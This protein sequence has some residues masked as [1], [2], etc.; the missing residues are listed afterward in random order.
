[1]RNFLIILILSTTSF[2]A[3]TDRIFST[4]NRF[5]SSSVKA[6]A[7]AGIA[8]PTGIF[9]GL[10]NPALTFSNHQCMNQYNGNVSAGYG[11][12]SIFNRYILPAGLTYSTDEGSMGLFCR[13][14]K[15][16]KSISQQEI[17]INFAGQMFTKSD[18]QGSVDFGMNFRFE[19]MVWENRPAQLQHFFANDSGEWIKEGSPETFSTSQ[20]NSIR[21]KR[22]LL[23][24][25][26]FQPGILENI[27]FGLV[28]RNL[29]GYVWTYGNSDTVFYDTL[30]NSLGI[31]SAMEKTISFTNNKSSSRG[32][33]GGINRTLTT[34]FT[35][36]AAIGNK[37]QL[38]I[39]LDF[40]FRGLFNKNI[41]NRCFFRG[42]LEADIAGHVM[43]RFG[44]ARAPGRL[45]ST[46]QEIKNINIFTGGAGMRIS[47]VSFDLYATSHAFGLNGSF[48]Y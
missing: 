9:S 12:D 10:I 28:V 3:N 8:L 44:Y 38:N 32:W 39:P 2:A 35:Y 27:D 20:N 18:N 17:V 46:W 5:Y 14:M 29:L 30:R 16:E 31:D 22:A 34:G 21:D 11:Q 7:D 26:F 41:K 36:H 19:K 6:M 1:M 43:L 40:E 24:I 25:G 23:D 42:G 48:N 33:T 15:G 4:Q 47:S 13:F 45:R 37:M